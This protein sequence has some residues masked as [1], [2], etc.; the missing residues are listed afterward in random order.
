MSQF[1]KESTLKRKFYQKQPKVKI[2]VLCEGKVT[3]PEYINQFAKQHANDKVIV[4]PI[5][6]VGVPLTVSQKAVELKAQLLRDARKSKDS[7]DM[8]FSVWC[9][10]DID[11]HPNVAEAKC[12][13]DSNRINFLISNPCFELWGLLHLKLQDAYIHRH[14]LQQSL[15]KEMPNY[16][17]TRNP[18]F[19]YKQ[20][21]GDYQIAKERAITICTRRKDEGK[22]NGN[23]STNV[24]ELFDYIIAN[25]R[26]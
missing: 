19:D 23:P 1:P 21:K 7:F 22:L 16:H 15:H 20:I 9:V 12:L 8:S 11:E 14:K 13:A 5:P 17:H 2:Y 10:V 3:E 25:G 6:G 4:Q 24:F 18:V 26:K